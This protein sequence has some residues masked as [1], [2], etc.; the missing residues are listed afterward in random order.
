MRDMIT[1]KT[2]KALKI[3]SAATWERPM[4]AK[5]FALLLWGNDP[6]KEY[7]FNSNTNTGNG[8]CSGKKAWLC[9]GS[10]LSKLTKRG[11]VHRFARNKEEWHGYLLTEKGKQA[12]KEYE[13]KQNN[14]KSPSPTDGGRTEKDAR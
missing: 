10:L 2:Y 12:I 13:S 9:A 11:L 7:L 14:Q 4:H 3:L 1:D 6:S 5:D 8:A